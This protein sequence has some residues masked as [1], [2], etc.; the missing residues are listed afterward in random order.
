VRIFDAPDDTP[1]VVELR[2]REFR[3]ATEAY[4]RTAD[5]R[6]LEGD[7]VWWN[8]CRMPAGISTGVY[9]PTT[10]TVMPPVVG[11]LGEWLDRDV[12]YEPANTAAREA[13]VQALE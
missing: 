11:R 4:E 10:V 12:A 2:P 1:L 5:P 7:W 6:A 8:W 13:L 3:A 9:E